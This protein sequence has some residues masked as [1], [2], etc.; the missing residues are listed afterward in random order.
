M[1]VQLKN[2][3]LRW[4]CGFCAGAVLPHTVDYPQWWPMWVIIVATGLLARDME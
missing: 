3:L 4:T 2:R 1:T